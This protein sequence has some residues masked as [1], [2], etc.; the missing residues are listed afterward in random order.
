[1]LGGIDST[2]NGAKAKDVIELCRSLADSGFQHFIVSL[3]N[4]A[5]ITPLEFIG[6]EII[7]EVAEF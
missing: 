5:E 3:P 4:V 6:R 7:P 2:A 1:V